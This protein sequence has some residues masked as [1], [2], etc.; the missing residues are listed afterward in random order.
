MHEHKAILIQ[1]WLKVWSGGLKHPDEPT[2]IGGC[3]FVSA[4]PHEGYE[5]VHM[6][7]QLDLHDWNVVC[8]I[9]GAVI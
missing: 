9:H 8:N 2:S 6:P 5:F 7:Y 3:S 4:I 1:G